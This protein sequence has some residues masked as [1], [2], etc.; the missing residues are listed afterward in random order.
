MR[1][2]GDRPEAARSAVTPSP[3]DAGSFPV[4]GKQLGKLAKSLRKRMTE[5]E[6]W[7]WTELRALRSQG[8]RFRR[9]VVLGEFIVDFACFQSRVVVELDGN[10]HAL[11]HNA[12]RDAK[13]DAWLA[14]QGFAVRRY[15]NAELHQDIDSVVNGIIHAAR[16]LPLDGEG[17]RGSAA[18]PVG[19]GDPHYRERTTL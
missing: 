19:R 5:E 13:R 1:R 9:Q 6:C 8:F 18:S 4:K 10:Q 3:R 7:L 15:W 2:Q 14:A 12:A 11:P 16:L 17:G